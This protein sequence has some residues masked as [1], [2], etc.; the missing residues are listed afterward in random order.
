MALDGLDAEFPEQ[1][2]FTTKVVFGPDGKNSIGWLC[3]GETDDQD[4]QRG[5]YLIQAVYSGR[6]WGF[7]AKQI[8]VEALRRVQTRI[9]GEFQ[10][11]GN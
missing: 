1:F 5:P 8:V 6:Q 9:G 11:Y 2:G 4:E 10:D 3:V 7:D